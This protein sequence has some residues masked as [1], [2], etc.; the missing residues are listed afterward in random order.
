VYDTNKL[1]MKTILKFLFPVKPNHPDVCGRLDIFV[2]Y[3]PVLDYH[4]LDLCICIN[5]R[6]EVILNYYYIILF[7]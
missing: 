6:S 5:C 3:G 2:R 1:T 7:R 4:V